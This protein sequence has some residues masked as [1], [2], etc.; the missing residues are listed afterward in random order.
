MKPSLLL[1]F[2]SSM[3]NAFVPEESSAIVQQTAQSCSSLRLADYLPP[4]KEG[5]RR[6]YL[7]RHGE[8]DWNRAGKIQGGG[9]DI[10]LNENGRRQAQLVAEE[11]KGLPIGV[12]ASSHLKRA[13]ET[14][15]VLHRVAA[16]NSKR[17]I[18]SGF[19]EMRFGEFEGIAHRSPEIDP[20]LKDRFLRANKEIST[21]LDAK[22]PG[23]GESTRDVQKRF[24][25]AIN[26][27]LGE[28]EDP[29]VVVVGHGRTNK[30][31]L[32]SLC[33]L[34]YDRI[35]QDS[36]YYTTHEG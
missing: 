29:H 35:Q 4:L 26:A 8:T 34:Q 18:H 22:Y 19:G 25:A 24:L 1:R 6:L 21:N 2:V 28:S 15:D 3:V 14:A 13:S 36:K 7:V 30:I 11:M 23:D 12:V 27:V 32:S 9:F 5:S 17:T 33:G 20:E 16:I 31:G 10:E